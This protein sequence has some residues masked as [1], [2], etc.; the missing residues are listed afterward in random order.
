MKKFVNAVLT[1]FLLFGVVKLGLSQEKEDEGLKLKINGVYTAWFQKQQNFFFGRLD[2]DYDDNYVVQMLRLNFNFAVSEHLKA[3]TRLD[4]AQGWWGVDNDDFRGDFDGDD[5]SNLSSRFSNKDTNYGIHVDL[6]YVDF[7]VPETSFPINIRLGRMY[8]GLGNKIVLDADLDGVQVDFK[9]KSGTLGLGWAKVSE[10]LDAITDNETVDALGNVLADGEDADLAF[11]RFNR[12]TQSGNISYGLFG[13][14]YN[15]RGD[16]DGTTF[17][18]NGLDYARTRFAPNICKLGA[19]GVTL[20]YNNKD[21]G[22]TVK[23]E[24]DYLTGKDDVANTN[25]GPNQSMDV[26]DGDING[27]NFYVKANKD[28]SPKV[29]LG[30]TF[31]LGSGDDDPTSGNGNVNKLKTMGFFYITELWEDSIMPDEEGITP[32][33]LGAPNTRGYRELENT[34]IIQG[35]ILV[36]PVPKLKLFGS[37]SLIRA[38]EDIPGWGDTDTDGVISTTEFTGESSKSIGSEIDFKIDYNIYKQLVWT[39]RGGYL[40]TGDA[41]QLLI[42]GNTQSDKNPWELKMTVTYRF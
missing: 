21:L 23:G 11:A 33:G 42:N 12:T 20:D 13:M 24:F 2:P 19:F 9:T 14:Y 41:A 27:Y 30:L 39:L 4:V 38:T 6:A 8:Y 26:N 10:G 5:N 29:N 3:V 34:T 36:K 16:D 31:G 1:L 22:L 18:P 28:L 7:T 32:Q 40:I 37:Y 25:S 17:L 15:D 35:N